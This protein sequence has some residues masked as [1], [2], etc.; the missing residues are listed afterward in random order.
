MILSHA[1]SLFLSL[2]AQ[3]WTAPGIL[4][5]T[6]KLSLHQR[7]R[8]DFSLSASATLCHERSALPEVNTQELSAR[9][10]VDGHDPLTAQ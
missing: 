3:A 2:E 7:L 8:N 6:L 10:Q 4:Y 1:R 9:E 5:L